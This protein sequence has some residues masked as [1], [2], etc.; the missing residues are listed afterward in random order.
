EPPLQCAVAAARE[1]P[2]G[3]RGIGVMVDEDGSPTLFKA[4]HNA[5]AAAESF[6]R[7]VAAVGRARRFAW[8]FP[9]DDGAWLLRTCAEFDGVEA[10][11]SIPTIAL[12]DEQGRFIADRAR[13]E[14]GNPL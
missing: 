14:E 8:R 12:E 5:G 11:D 13:Y 4:F 1:I 6:D 7:A 2:P 10:V 9:D 3:S